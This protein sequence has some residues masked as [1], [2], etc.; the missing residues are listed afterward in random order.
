MQSA[1]TKVDR[2][3]TVYTSIIVAL[4]NARQWGFTLPGDIA[5]CIMQELDSNGLRIVRSK[6]KRRAEGKG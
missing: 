4:D 3:K 6:G 1:Q 2:T 5:L